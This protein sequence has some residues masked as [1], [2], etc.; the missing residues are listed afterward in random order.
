MKAGR[1][2][3]LGIAL[4]VALMF[5]CVTEVAAWTLLPSGV[6][7]QVGYYGNTAYHSNS[8][9]YT[10]SPGPP[11]PGIEIYEFSGE[12]C[13]NVVACKVGIPDCR[14]CGVAIELNWWV[15][16]PGG[17]PGQLQSRDNSANHEAC[18]ECDRVDADGMNQGFQAENIRVQI[19]AYCYCCDESAEGEVFYWD[20]VI[21][22]WP[23]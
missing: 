21:H 19:V 15:I 14:K 3:L 10:W 11:L 5:V 18:P 16:A 6:T 9:G 2:T 4:T 8:Y 7:V 23:M 12:A 13:C 1:V 17:V 22:D 20:T